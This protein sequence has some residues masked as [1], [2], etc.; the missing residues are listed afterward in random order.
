[1][2]LTLFKNL[3]YGN[4]NTLKKIE[5]IEH[6]I[7]CYETLKN[8]KH[9]LIGGLVYPRYTRSLTPLHKRCFLAL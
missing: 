3:Q 4:N 9:L 2:S 5:Q 7:A 6:R 1:M 8:L